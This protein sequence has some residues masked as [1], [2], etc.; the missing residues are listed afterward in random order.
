MIPVGRFPAGWLDGAEPAGAGK[1]GRPT[2]RIV[3]GSP[4]RPRVETGPGRGLARQ[5]SM[6]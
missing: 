6:N 5:R 1:A 4:P 3:A 2:L